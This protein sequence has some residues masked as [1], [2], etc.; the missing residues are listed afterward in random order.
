MKK[1]FGIILL[2][3]GI[4]IA[5][6]A[7]KISVGY[8]LGSGSMFL[9]EKND[10][11]VDI[12]YAAPFASFV[13]FKYMPESVPINV[14]IEW[15][16]LNTG[17]TGTNWM[18]HNAVDGEVSSLTT[19]LIFEYLKNEKKLNFGGHIGIGYSHENY[20]ENLELRTAKTDKRNFMS[21]SIAG[22]ASLKMS[23]R[24]SLQ[25]IPSLLWSDPVNSF[26]DS[27]Q[28]NIAGEDLSFLA[29]VGFS[30]TLN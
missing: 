22:I 16:Y 13:N 2:L 26:R 8:G 23:D 29:Q 17:I 25:F 9:F 28:W 27:S 6:N 1:L 4:F 5:A 20:I 30:Y 12:S 14:K 15:Q 19:L 7:Q 21:I 18:S 10:N 11:A 3:F 24:F